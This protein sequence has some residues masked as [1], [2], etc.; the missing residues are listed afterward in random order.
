MRGRRQQRQQFVTP[1]PTIDDAAIG[2]RRNSARRTASYS[3]A[4][5]RDATLRYPRRRTQSPGSQ[6]ITDR[7]WAARNGR[8]SAAAAAVRS[9]GFGYRATAGPQF[10]RQLD[11]RRAAGDDGD[12][13][14]TLS[15]PSR[16]LPARATICSRSAVPG[17]GPTT[18][19]GRREADRSCR[20]RASERQQARREIAPTGR[21][22]FATLKAPSLGGL[23]PPPPLLLLLLP[24]PTAKDAGNR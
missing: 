20:A 5:R 7:C 8:P 10:H 4:T 14:A 11:G 22:Q 13:R 16:R 9:G 19:I 23:P 2:G 1:G 15:A 17:R 12:A 6:A 24:P 21:A 3:D 18:P